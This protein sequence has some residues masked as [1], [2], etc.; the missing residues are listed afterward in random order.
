MKCTLCEEEITPEQMGWGTIHRECG[1][2][3]G[4]GGIGHLLDHHHFCP[5]DTD[6]GLDYRTSALMVD[7]Y[8]QRLNSEGEHQ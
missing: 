5:Q 7:V 4:M 2:R 1:L 8:I 3:A 6:A